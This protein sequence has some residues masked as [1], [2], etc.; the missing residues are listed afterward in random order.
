MVTI[1]QLV[2]LVVGIAGKRIGKKHI[3]GRGRHSDNRLIREKLH[4][5]PTQLARR[6]GIDLSMGRTA[7]EQEFASGL[8]TERQS[9]TAERNIDG[10]RNSSGS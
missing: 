6:T 1:N 4:W 5:E 3:A 8:R 7:G 10:R 9:F 2:D